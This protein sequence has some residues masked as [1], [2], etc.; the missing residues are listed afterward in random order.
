MDKGTETLV[1][2]GVEEEVG[3]PLL[4]NAT[5]RRLL[6]YMVRG[7]EFAGANRKRSSTVGLEAV[8]AATLI[9]LRAGDTVALVGDKWIAAE[10]GSPLRRMESENQAGADFLDDTSGGA[11][12]VGIATGLAMGRKALGNGELVVVLGTTRVLQEKAAQQ[13]MAVAGERKLPILYLVEVNMA[14]GKAPLSDD[15]INVKALGFGFP[16]IPVDGNDAVAVYRVVQEATAR[17]RKNGGPTLIVCKTF[18]RSAMKGRRGGKGSSWVAKDP[19][20]HM[21]EYLRK[22]GIQS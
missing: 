6:G 21:R 17:A 14:E 22:K 7:R 20:E 13:A 19:V 4:S 12:Q 15:Q 3:N 18:R 5:L 8:E 16:A 1:A 11:A 2:T 10:S 9:Q